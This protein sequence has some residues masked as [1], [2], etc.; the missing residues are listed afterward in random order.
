MPFERGRDLLDL[1]TGFA[2]EVPGLHEA[3]LLLVAG[4][5]EEKVRREEL[6]LSDQDDVPHSQLVVLGFFELGH[7]AFPVG[8]GLL[9]H[10]YVQGVL[11]LEVRVPRLCAGV[12]GRL[13]EQFDVGLVGL[14]EVRVALGFFGVRGRRAVLPKASSLSLWTFLLF[15]RLSL[16]QRL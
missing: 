13:L 8:L 11:F 14:V 3:P 16:F 1:E 5:Q 15:S 12:L 10:L 2:V 9:E 7:G 6:V 4:L